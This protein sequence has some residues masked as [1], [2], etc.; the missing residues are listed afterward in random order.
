MEEWRSTVLSKAVAVGFIVLTLIIAACS[1]GDSTTSTPTPLGNGNGSA[2]TAASHS[3]TPASAT[4]SSAASTTPASGLNDACSLITQAEVVAAV[5]KPVGPGQSLNDGKKCEFEYTDPS[6]PLGG[7]GAA[8][9]IDL[10]QNVFTG[11]QSGGIGAVPVSGV[12]DEAYFTNAGLLGSL[13][14]FRK[15]SLLFETSILVAGSVKT[16]FPTSAQQAAT[17]AMAQ[18]ALPR[19]P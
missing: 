12:G 7:L 17:T 4:A 11:D 14:D 2:T 10:D 6:D 18:A 1:S 5:G 13:L 9:D 15:G 16:E 8:L 3:A 19:I